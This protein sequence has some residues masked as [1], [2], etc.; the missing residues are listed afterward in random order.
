MRTGVALGLASMKQFSPLVRKFS[1]QI[2]VSSK[3]HIFYAYCLFFYLPIL[4]AS[5]FDGCHVN[6]GKQ[7]GYMLLFAFVGLPFYTTNSELKEIFT[8]FGEVTEGTISLPFF[9]FWKK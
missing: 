3:I 4:L 7:E 8:P 5:T 9:F 2:Y 6:N 1:S